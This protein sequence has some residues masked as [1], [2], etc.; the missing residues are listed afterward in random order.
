M[1]DRQAAFTWIASL[2]LSSDLVTIMD[3]LILSLPTLND[4]RSHVLDTLCAHDGLDPT[5]TRLDQ[6]MIL[7]RGKPCGLFFHLSGPRLLRTSAV[8]AGPEDRIFFYDSTGQR[9]KETRLTDAPDPMDP[10][11]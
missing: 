5:Q 6:A 8:W 2:T 9:Y 7:Q 11:A 10:A 1:T 3:A 4:L